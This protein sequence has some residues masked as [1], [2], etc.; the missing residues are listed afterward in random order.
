MARYLNFGDKGIPDGFKNVNK[1]FPEGLV[2]FNIPHDSIKNR[3]KLRKLISGINPM[4]VVLVSDAELEKLAWNANLF[5][6]ISNKNDL[7]RE[8][9]KLLD[10]LFFLRDVEK[11]PR[12]LKLRHNNGYD[13]LKLE[14]ILYC[15]A[16]GNYS[17]VYFEGGKKKTY[18]LQLKKLNSYLSKNPN[19]VRIGKSL[20]I[21]LKHI[22]RIKKEEIIFQV[23]NENQY[24]SLSPLMIRRLKRELV[25]L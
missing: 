24:L 21:N 13:V 9:G 20:I 10:R 23:S 6:F 16:D 2:F 18:T 25:W 5:H 7:H 17:Q 3:L 15:K 11:V 14:D 1:L 8:L 4:R 12:R 19:I 22:N